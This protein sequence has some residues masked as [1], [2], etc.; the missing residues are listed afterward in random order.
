[1]KTTLLT[2]IMAATPAFAGMQGYS[3]DPGWQQITGDTSCIRE[4]RAVVVKD[5]E[6]WEKLWKQHSCDVSEA[7]QLPPADF[8]GERVIA[9]FLGWRASAGYKVE[10][11]LKETAS[12]PPEL[13]VTY[14][15]KAPEQGKFHAGLMSQPWVLRKVKNDYSAVRI[16]TRTAASV[17][18]ESEKRIDDGT[19]LATTKLVE[20]GW[21][22]DLGDMRDAM[23]ARAFFDGSAAKTGIPTGLGG[24]IAYPSTAEGMKL[25]GLPP[26]PGQK[27]KQGGKLPPPPTREQ[28][29]QDQGGKKLPPPPKKDQGKKLPPPPG[30]GKPLPPPPGVKLPRPIYPG[31]PLPS[32][33]PRL[34]NADRTYST[35]GKKY[36]GYWRGDAYY[37]TA[38][39]RLKRTPEDIG[40]TFRVNLTS[41]RV[42]KYYLFY[43]DS[44]DREITWTPT[45]KEIER[46]SKNLVI[47]F[48]ND[49]DKPMMPWE[50]E[51]FVFSLRGNTVSLDSQSGS[52]R[53][54]VL[55]TV[56]PDNPGTIVAHMTA[57][58]KLRTSPDPKG[59]SAGI[60]ATGNGLKLVI[61]DKWSEEYAGEDL[62]ITYVIRRDDG[63][64]YSRDDIVQRATSGSP[65]RIRATEVYEHGITG[66][67]ASKS[68]EFYL[69]S[70]SFRRAGSHISTSRW[71][72]KGKGN[73]ITK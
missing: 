72:G 13:V 31:G 66:G 34:E 19:Q 5:A 28:E 18:Q 16:P 6:S 36:I 29:R 21:L 70:W 62:E 57:G 41:I 3:T 40:E 69:E 52:Y 11:D 73:T 33:D 32:N 61:R 4:L 48:T 15:E 42:R 26:P 55:F 64:W 51:S 54:H 14:S 50:A 46:R 39:G 47:E 12:N 67:F 20:G 37:K 71:I 65:L 53:Y 30:V 7:P 68:G 63:H 43:Y 56:N 38:Q 27:K 1:M 60:Q 49:Y 9:V 58:D 22:A 10:L 35:Y 8:G 2:L 23:G 24:V 44:E 25:A 45:E 17:P 59:V